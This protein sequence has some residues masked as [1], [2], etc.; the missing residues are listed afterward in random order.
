MLN[1]G[2][3]IAVGDDAS[4]NH[5][6]SR[7][8]LRENILESCPSVQELFNNA[9]KRLSPKGAKGGEPDLSVVSVMCL[10]SF[11]YSVSHVSLCG[12]T[13]KH[14]CKVWGFLERQATSSSYSMRSWIRRLVGTRTCEG[15][16]AYWNITRPMDSRVPCDIIPDGS[17]SKCI[18]ATYHMAYNIY[19]QPTTVEESAYCDIATSCKIKEALR[20]RDISTD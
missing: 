4:S 17:W 16:M 10:A 15:Y 7:I 3:T 1:P 2:Y 11:G 14:M 9:R 8:L 18:N 5:E 19:G 13:E 20:L 12:I 6:D